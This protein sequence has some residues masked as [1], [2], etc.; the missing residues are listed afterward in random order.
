MFSLSREY[1]FDPSTLEDEGSV[2]LQ[3]IGT[4]Q[5]TGTPSYSR[6]PEFSQVLVLFG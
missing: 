1:D 2:F 3:N 5:P 4:H 6:R